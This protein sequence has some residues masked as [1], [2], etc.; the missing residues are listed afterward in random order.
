MGEHCNLVISQSAGVVISVQG[1]LWHQFVLSSES[2]LV[3]LTGSACLC[4]L[5]ISDGDSQAIWRGRQ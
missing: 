2:W 3:G 5:F 4:I 1:R